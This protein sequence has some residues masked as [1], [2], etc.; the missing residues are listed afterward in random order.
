MNKGLFHIFFAHPFIVFI[1]SAFLGTM[2]VP[3]PVQADSFK[4]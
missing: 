3:A 1:R 2:N 4:Q